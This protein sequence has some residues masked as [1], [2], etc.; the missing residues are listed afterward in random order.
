MLAQ[1][2]KTMYLPVIRGGGGTLI[3]RRTLRWGGRPPVD[4]AGHAD[5]R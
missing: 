4:L 2:G 3:V 5:D 1:D